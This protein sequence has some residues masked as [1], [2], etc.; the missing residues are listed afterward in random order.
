MV[1]FPPNLEDGELW[2]P[3]DIY[4]EIISGTKLEALAPNNITQ[5]CDLEIKSFDHGGTREL[6]EKNCPFPID[7]KGKEPRGFVS[8]SRGTGVFLPKTSVDQ[9]KPLKRTGVFLQSFIANAPLVIHKK[10][11]CGKNEQRIEKKFIV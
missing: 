10:K 6:K 11:K 8:N 2:L 9:S 1:D 5:E 4:Q 3:S 7:E